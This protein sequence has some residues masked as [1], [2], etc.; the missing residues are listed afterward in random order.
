MKKIP[1]MA[2]KCPYCL[3]QNQMV[4]GRVG[5]LLILIIGALVGGKCYFE[6]KNSA[7]DNY[8]IEH[9]K[10]SVIKN[11]DNPRK[12]LDELFKNIE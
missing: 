9:K 11:V 10:N 1:L 12:E 2:G 4:H 6:G 7:A 8:L 3:E 5:F